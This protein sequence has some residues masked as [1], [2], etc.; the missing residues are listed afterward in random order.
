MVK[1]KQRRSEMGTKKEENKKDYTIVVIAI[2]VVIMVVWGIGVLLFNKGAKG[3]NVKPAGENGQEQSETKKTETQE[4]DFTQ[5]I[6]DTIEGNYYI[7]N[8]LFDTD[9]AKAINAE[10]LKAVEGRPAESTEENPYGIGYNAYCN[11]GVLSLE[12]IV[13]DTSSHYYTYNVDTESGLKLSNADLLAKFGLKEETVLEAIKSSVT[14]LF[15]SQYVVEE[16]TE[17]YKAAL[18]ATVAEVNSD[19]KMYINESTAL[20]SVIKMHKPGS[21]EVAENLVVLGLDGLKD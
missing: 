4:T 7:P 14:S 13:S 17:E 9:D 15:R 18:D 8:L 20:V 19:M 21:E 10:I 11:K 16:E 6:S 12:M 2:V 1:V 3:G 5:W